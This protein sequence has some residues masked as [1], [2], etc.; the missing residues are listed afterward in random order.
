M[1]K[2][3]RYSL[4]GVLVLAMLVSPTFAWFYNDYPEPGRAAD[5]NFEMFGPRCDRLLIKLYAAAEGEWDALK[6]TPQELD[7]TDWPLEKS[8]YD[9]FIVDPPLGYADDVY[10]VSVKGEFGL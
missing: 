7:L 8:Y 9:Q 10:V 1:R 6:A 2:S 4:I 5:T 3:L